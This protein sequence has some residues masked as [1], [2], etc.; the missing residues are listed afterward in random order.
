[1]KGLEYESIL[2]MEPREREWYLNRL[3]QQKQRETEAIGQ[4]A[5]K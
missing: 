5:P 2:E 1:M 3:Y 4:P